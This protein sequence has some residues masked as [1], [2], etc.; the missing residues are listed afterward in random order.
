MLGCTEKIYEVH[1][2]TR[3]VPR[4]TLDGEKRS[5][6]NTRRRKKIHE[7][8]VEIRSILTLCSA[9]TDAGNPKFEN[10]RTRW[11]HLIIMSTG[12]QQIRLSL[13]FFLYMLVM[14]LGFVGKR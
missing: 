14:V 1:S 6:K 8:P 11:W 12:E 4:R 2:T 10:Q 5:T 3:K 7:D 13:A 9:D